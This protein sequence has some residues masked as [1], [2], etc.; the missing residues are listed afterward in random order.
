MS[1]IFLILRHPGNKILNK[2]DLNPTDIVSGSFKKGK[3]A[4]NPHSNLKDLTQSLKFV[5]DGMDV[6]VVYDAVNEFLKSF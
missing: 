3:L 4:V 1:S 2:L 5:R 6:V